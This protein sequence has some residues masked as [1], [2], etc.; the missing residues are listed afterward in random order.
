AAS[1]AG[2][3][4]SIH[5]AASLRVAPASRCARSAPA[6]CSMRLHAAGPPGSAAA[7]AAPF[8]SAIRA[9]AVRR[10]SNASSSPATPATAWRVTACDSRAS[11]T[12]GSLPSAG[13][14]SQSAAA[15]ATSTTPVSTVSS[16]KVE[17]LV[18]PGPSRLLSVLWDVLA[19][20]LNR[21]EQECLYAV[22]SVRGGLQERRRLHQPEQVEHR[23][24][25]VSSLVGAS[26]VA[27]AAHHGRRPA[28]AVLL[29]QEAPEAEHLVHHQPGG[30]LAMVHGDHARLPLER[31]AAAPQEHLEIDERQEVP[32]QVRDAE[33]PA[34]RP[35]HPRRRFR[36][37]EHLADLL[38][39]RDEPLLAE[40]KADADP[41]GRGP[42]HRVTG[43]RGAAAPLELQ[44]ELEGVV[45]ELR[46][47][48]G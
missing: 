39:R 4:C 46:E 14:P 17:L 27:I 3:C 33:H 47:V 18:A 42:V 48:G 37:H 24:A 15:A 40:A 26:E 29:R 22:A 20:A 44:E 43:D 32:A 9:S 36:Q 7:G 35:R 34:L 5:A 12:G 38:P 6:C 21:F 1:V 8:S 45:D 11:S 25:L 31:R 2:T 30:N 16:M 10:R 23:P 19:M 13:R 41:F 28:V